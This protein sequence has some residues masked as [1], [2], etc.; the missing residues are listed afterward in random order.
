MQEDPLQ[1][2]SRHRDCGTRSGALERLRAENDQQRSLDHME[3]DVPVFG[4]AE[5]EA[6]R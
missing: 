5:I 4:D 1:L 3:V 2:T 6:R